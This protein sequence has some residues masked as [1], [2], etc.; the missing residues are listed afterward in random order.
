MLKNNAEDNARQ[1]VSDLGI[2]TPSIK[3]YVRNL[4]G[5]NQQKVILGKWLAADS[6]III[7]DEPTKGIDIGSKSEI[8]TLMRKLADEGKGVLVVSS[9]LPEL[10]AVCDTIAVFREGKI[11]QTFPHKDATEEKIIMASTADLKERTN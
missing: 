3:Q 2:A 8:Y 11:V 1:Y 10:L 4:S 6:Q 5:G 9:E 7:F